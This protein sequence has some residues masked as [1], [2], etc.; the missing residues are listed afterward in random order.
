MTPSPL[1]PLGPYEVL[2]KIGAGGMG[3]VYC[4][5]DARLGR[6]VAIKLLL[7]AFTSNV[8]RLVRFQQEIRTLAQLNHPNL[9]QVHDT[10]EHEGRPYLVMELL[11]GETLRQRMEGR[12][13]PLRKAV[14]IVHHVAKGLAAAHEKGITHRDLKPENIFV[15][16]DDRVKILDFGLAKL[17][18]PHDSEETLEL[19]PSPSLTE[20]G[21]V[22]GTV[23][24]LS[25]E[26]VVGR[27]AD[28]RSDIFALGVILWEMLT[29]MRPFQRES[30]VET[31]HAILKD[32]V[33]PLPPD[34]SLPFGLERILHRCLE[35]DPRARFQSA[36]DL[37]FHLESLPFGSLSQ[38]VGAE[39]L[40][41]PK[42]PSRAR[43]WIAAA[44]M[45]VALLGGA[46]WV[47]LEQATRAPLTLQRL[48]YQNGQI[49]S[50]RFAPDGLTFAFCISRGGAPPELWTGRTDAIGARPLDLPPGTDILSVSS[51][52]EMAI[53]L[54]REVGF[55]GTLA[56]VPLAGGAPRE[57]LEKVWGADWSP[58]GKEL[59]VIREGDRDRRRLEYPVGRLLF[60]APE[61]TLLDFPRV[62][63]D[64]KHVAFI[65]TVSGIAQL[66]IVD[67]TGTKTV[68]V[69]GGCGS[70][71]WSPDSDEILY[72]SRLV[73]DRRE[74]RAVTLKGRQRAVYS[75][76]GLLT[77][78]DISRTG[79]ILAD[80]TFTRTGI[81]AKL[82]EDHAEREVSWFQSS[83]VA[84]IS[85]DGSTILFG[86]MQEGSG[87]GGTYLR[88]L[89]Q[90]DAVRLGDG[91]PLYLSPD[92]KWAVVRTLDATPD[93][94]LLPTGPGEARRLP[95]HGLKPEWAIFLRDNLRLL[96]GGV[97]DRKVFRHYLQRIDTGEITFIEGDTNVDGYA[98]ASPDGAWLAIGPTH[99]QVHLHP[100]IG[101]TA[102]T[103]GGFE[104]G[105]W[106]LQ[107]SA[108]GAF[109]Y[110]ADPSQLPVRI[111]RVDV[112]SGKRSLWKE[113][114]PA[115]MLGVTGVSYV[116]IAPDGQ[117][118]AYSYHQTLTSDL[119]IM[120]GWKTAPADPR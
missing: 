52:G 11:E 60:E 53:L 9:L 24:Y 107:W 100:L 84:D 86:E 36:Q 35:K 13:L 65:H 40:P 37:A 69:D 49:T 117:S 119:F 71:A 25:P 68:L 97:D 104:D 70:L 81:L 47:G 73:E 41:V 34:V 2:S 58:D 63:P 89:G 8:D 93:L 78:H 114:A 111:Y 54:N 67:L 20:T 66:C 48:T 14:E 106:I 6:K 56:R 112:A 19:T 87:P 85:G 110:T 116:A 91:D 1:P 29:G 28:A 88:K 26:Q 113:L 3:E 61:G 96:V 95:S 74:I 118:Y 23:S 115:G 55:P 103:L 92:G 5:R 7:P 75:P 46:F 4:A 10:G 50:A 101:D 32:E 30:P 59:A 45:G 22:M 83:E 105:E 21:V 98:A 62:A 15:T 94:M 109:L 18:V 17:R 33:P 27:P 43:R 12:T 77:L 79:R 31:M 51:T 76:L 102:R 57:M 38:P 90:R 108:D 39:S 64:G 72:T 42:P 82:P 120:D 99:G 80:H 16:S 44:L